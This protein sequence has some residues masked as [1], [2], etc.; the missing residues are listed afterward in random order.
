MENSVKI[1]YRSQQSLAA[2]FLV[3]LNKYLKS[4]VIISYQPKETSSS[5]DIEIQIKGSDPLFGQNTAASIICK[6]SKLRTS[7][8]LG[9]SNFQDQWISFLFDLQLDTSQMLLLEFE[10]SVKAI[11]ADLV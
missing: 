1:F 11:E 8:F 3:N 5:L 10:A 6:N 7:Q 4:D 2:Y 9:E